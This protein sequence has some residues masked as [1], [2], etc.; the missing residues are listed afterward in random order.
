MRRLFL[1]FVLCL[2][3]GWQAAWADL[4][5]IVNARSGVAA[6]TR[7][8]V[9]HI[10]FGRNRLFFNGQEAHPVDLQGKHPVRLDFY[11]RLVGKELAEIDA[12]WSRQQFTGGARPPVQLESSAD[13][14][15]WVA[16]QPGAIG[17]VELPHADARVRVVYDFA[18]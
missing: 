15:E 17:F 8:E 6:M 1:L 2:G 12:Y 13:V 14:L 10:F 3:A 11:R 4:V 7:N 16:T 9:V 5:V 18:R